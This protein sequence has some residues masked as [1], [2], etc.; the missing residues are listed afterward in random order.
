MEKFIGKVVKIM[1][2]GAFVNFYRSKMDL[3][4][5]ELADKVAKSEM[6]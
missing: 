6:L 3:Y 5:F 1:E 4:I 2:F